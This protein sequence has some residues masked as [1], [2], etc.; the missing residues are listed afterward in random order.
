MM[1]NFEK[2]SFCEHFEHTDNDRST[3]QKPQTATNRF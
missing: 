2:T 1:I 3:I